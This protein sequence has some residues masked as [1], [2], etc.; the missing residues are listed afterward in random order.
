MSS[1]LWKKHYLTVSVLCWTVGLTVMAIAWKLRFDP[2]MVS[3]ERDEYM[4]RA[5]SLSKMWHR[6]LYAVICSPLFAYLHILLN[7]QKKPL[8]HNRLN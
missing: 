6:G 7:R 1:T 8:T 3:L 5:E 2:D 4:Q